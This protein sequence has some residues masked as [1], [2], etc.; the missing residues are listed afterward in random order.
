M[1]PIVLDHPADESD[2]KSEL[3]RQ[4]RLKNISHVIVGY[5]M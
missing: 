2:A 4:L 5:L 3:L 1:E